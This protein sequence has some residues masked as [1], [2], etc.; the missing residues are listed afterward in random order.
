[1]ITR[2]TAQK[3]YVCTYS[4]GGWIRSR[5]VYLKHAIKVDG[6]LSTLRECSQ[7]ATTNGRAGLLEKK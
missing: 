3:P 4:C 7:C 1:M 6:V 5:S 2:R